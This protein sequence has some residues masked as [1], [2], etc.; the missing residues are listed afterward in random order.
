MHGGA[1][2]GEI[3]CRIGP[4][5]RDRRRRI[6]RKEDH[7]RTRGADGRSR[8]FF[9]AAAQSDTEQPFGPAKLNGSVG[10]MSSRPVN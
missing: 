8:W 10:Q 6:D 7:W 1:G 4:L 9:G 2:R 5:K 3:P